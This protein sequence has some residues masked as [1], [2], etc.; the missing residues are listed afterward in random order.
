MN[1]NYMYIGKNSYCF[2]EIYTV[3]YNHVGLIANKTRL[4]FIIMKTVFMEHNEY[5][6]V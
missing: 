1:C 5:S 4:N 6:N 3:A 2:D